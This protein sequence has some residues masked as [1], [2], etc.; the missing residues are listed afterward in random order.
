MAQ[1]QISSETALR[2]TMIE[3]EWRRNRIMVLAQQIAETG[4]RVAE[5]EAELAAVKAAD[6]AD[7]E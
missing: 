7:I 2:E 1:V 4:K 5:L 3:S 6:P